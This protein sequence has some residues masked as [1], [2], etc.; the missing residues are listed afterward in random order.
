MQG[1]GVAWAEVD[2]GKGGGEM[3]ECCDVLYGW[4][5]TTRY[6]HN[7]QTMIIPASGCHLS[8]KVENIDR[9]AWTFSILYS[10]SEDVPQHAPHLG[11]GDPSP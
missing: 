6:W 10:G 8:N 4:P 3:R 7:S 5:I 11:E 9:M 1:R 2:M